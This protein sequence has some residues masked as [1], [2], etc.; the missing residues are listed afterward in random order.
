MKTSRSRILLFA[1]VGI[2]GIQL[3]AQSPILTV[4]QHGGFLKVIAPQFHFLTGKALDRLHD[5]AMVTYVI[6][7]AAITEQTQKPAFLL[8]ER[9]AVSFD[10]W[11]EKYSV[12]QA[13]KNGRSASRLTAAM[14]EAWCLEQMPLP[15]SSIPEKDSFLIRLKC[16]VDTTNSDGAG[17][18]GLELTLAG[19]IDVFSRKKSEAPLRWEAV[20]KPLHQ[21]DLRNTKQVR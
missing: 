7:L 4:E 2:L 8:E 14:T 19:L 12:I 6:T 10:L 13:Q 5:G 21:S 3:R 20:S 17:K 9:F 1:V 16:S 11:E 18:E 15:V